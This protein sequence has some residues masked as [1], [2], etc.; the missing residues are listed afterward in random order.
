MSKKPSRS[1]AAA[2]DQFISPFRIDGATKFHLTSHK[3]SEK[4]GLD[5]D[6]AEKSST[7]TA[8]G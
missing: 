6:K 5:K 7:P 3:T 4:G 2:L 1:V 8:A